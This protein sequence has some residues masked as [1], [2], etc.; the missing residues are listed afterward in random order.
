MDGARDERQDCQILQH[1]PLTEVRGWWDIN[2]YILGSGFG[3]NGQEA[4]F[5]TIP[6][7]PYFTESRKTCH[8][9]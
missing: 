1:T 7:S 3:A 9:R 6:I 4:T 5:G 2:R 8:D